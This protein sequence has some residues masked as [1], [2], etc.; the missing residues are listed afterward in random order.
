MQFGND[1]PL[2]CRERK[3]G[4]TKKLLSADVARAHNIEPRQIINAM[5]S[6]RD[7]GGIEHL[8][9]EIPQQAMGF[10]DFIE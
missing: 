9:E 2:Q 4:R 3:A 6:E 10:F 8:Q 5:I 7:A 1:G